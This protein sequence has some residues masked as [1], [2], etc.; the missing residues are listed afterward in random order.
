M[1]NRKISLFSALG[2]LL[3]SGAADAAAVDTRSSSIVAVY[4]QMGVSVEAPFQ[5]F[6]G[7]IVFDPAHPEQASAELDVVTGSIDLG[8]EQY[9]A[10][11]RK[12]AWFDSSQFP[13]AHFA[14]TVV[15]LL[16]DGQ[17]EAS[18]NFTLKGRTQPLTVKLSRTARSGQAVYSGSFQLSRAAWGIGDKSWNDVLDDKVT[19]RFQL[20]TPAS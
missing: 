20:V 15:K 7:A 16:A 17:L 4:S 18:G 14:A 9:S 10:E 13:D 6:S 1:I 12:P 5:K 11:A 8:D 2:L 3:L 19:V